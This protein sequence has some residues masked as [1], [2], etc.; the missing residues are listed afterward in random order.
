VRKLK[1]IG[2][3]QMSRDHRGTRPGSRVTPIHAL[4]GAAILGLVIMPLAFAGAKPAVV[5]KSA[6]AKR[7]LLSL[8]RRVAALER[9]P[10]PKIPTTLPP[11]GP[12]GGDLV[13]NFPNPQIGPNTLG[14][15]QLGPVSIVP[16]DPLTI[17]PGHTAHP[18]ATCPAGT[19]LIGGGFQWQ[20]D[21]TDGTAINE[22]FPLPGSEESEWVVEGRVDT[23]GAATALKAE[24]FCLSG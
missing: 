5:T 2:G 15:D 11:S 20:D 1:P 24:A 19:R 3:E 23:G 16:S 9:T 8:K 10:A 17:Q 18:V 4:L 6:S 13:G 12:A 7:Q 21:T 14:A 22:S